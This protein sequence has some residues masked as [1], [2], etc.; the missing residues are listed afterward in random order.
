M[1]LVGSDW[2]AFIKFCINSVS[3]SLGFKVIGNEF[4]S[5]I[6]GTEDAAVRNVTMFPY[7]VSTELVIMVVTS[8]WVFGD[9]PVTAR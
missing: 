9:N 4:G 5:G 6:I 2:K 7:E 8:Y 3:G 1:R